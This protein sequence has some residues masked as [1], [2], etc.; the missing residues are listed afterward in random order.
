MKITTMKTLVYLASVG[1]CHFWGHTASAQTP[2]LS[3]PA[4]AKLVLDED[5]AT[6]RIDPAR[7]Y[8][9]HKQWGNGNHGVVR[10]NKIIAKDVVAGK[11]KNVLICRGHGDEYDG[12]V[13]GWEGNETRVGGVLVSKAF[14]ASGKFEVVM[15]IGTSEST[16]TS[17]SDPKCPVGMVPAIW[18]YAYR[19][20]DSGKSDPD[21]FTRSN[22]LFNPHMRNEYW[23]EIDMPE[24]GKG[25]DFSTG[26]YNTFLNV[27]HQSRRYPTNNAV[28]GK[29]HTY[30]S[31]WRTHLIP[32]DGVTDSQVA[33]SEGFWWIQDKSIP[34]GSYRGNPL[35]RLGRDRYALY[36]GN[37]VNHFI[38]G[39]YVGSNPT[40]VPVMAA[41]LNIGVWFP[42]WGG[43]SP[44]AESQV[45]IASVKVWQFGDAGDVRGILKEDIPANMDSD[46]VPLK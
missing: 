8:A 14:F 23:S 11:S 18:T 16:S 5:W 21:S 3:V 10:Q 6:G 26:L 19:W 36:A 35:K 12:P 7:W 25:Q 33:E 1:I 43:A 45:S 32:M 37:V 39:E 44:W 46:G 13:K 28:D 20:V 42:D 27:N 2:I 17:P 34:F 24:F 9:L 4:G 41:Q 30:T 22:P 15:K 38:D 31:V 40:F 29:Y